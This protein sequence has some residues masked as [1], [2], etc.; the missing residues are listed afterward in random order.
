MLTINCINVFQKCSTATA[1]HRASL[2]LSPARKVSVKTQTAFAALRVLTYSRFRRSVGLYIYC[3][4]TPQAE[5]RH[6]WYFSYIIN[7]NNNIFLQRYSP[8]YL[9]LNARYSAKEKQQQKLNEPTKL[10]Q[11]IKK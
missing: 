4:V 3:T 9:G 7:N 10:T 11:Y 5:C 2:S 8:S 6:C 1:L